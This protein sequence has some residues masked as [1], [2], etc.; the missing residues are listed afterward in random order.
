MALAPAK[1][2]ADVDFSSEYEQ[3]AAGEEPSAASLQNSDV[4]AEETDESQA[5]LPSDES[6]GLAPG[7]TDEPAGELEQEPELTPEELEEQ[8]RQDILAA[9]AEARR[10]Q[11]DFER[12]H[13]KPL[14]APEVLEQQR[15]INET[16][17]NVAEEMPD[18]MTAIQDQAQRAI[19]DATEQAQERIA[20]AGLESAR[21]AHIATILNAHP[22]ALELY[23]N[24]AVIERW[25]ETLPYGQGQTYAAVLENGYANE[26]INLLSDFKD[27]VGIEDFSQFQPEM[28]D[29]PMTDVDDDD[30]A[31]AAGAVPS[32]NSRMA[33]GSDAGD[34]KDE[35]SAGYDE[36]L[37]KYEEDSQP[38]QR[39]A[40]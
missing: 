8:E 13:G 34:G 16:V 15:Q 31:A 30:A 21:D 20:E 7:D 37:R 24:R 36:A 11:L 22:D 17:Q 1:T 35:F 27:S 29:Q 33:P 18:V 25:I 9:S 3:L 12:R 10:A 2:Q 39:R 40:G 6:Q 5:G 26:V 23:E 4:A 28:L 19:E 14:V 32:K 38:Q